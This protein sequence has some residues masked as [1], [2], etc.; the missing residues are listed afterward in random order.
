MAESNS[1]TNEQLEEWLVLR[2]KATPAD[3]HVNHNHDENCTYI[4]GDVT[5]AYDPIATV[6]WGDGNAA[7]HRETANVEFICVSF[8]HFADT[9]RALIEERKRSDKR[10]EAFKGAHVLVGIT[11]DMQR[12]AESLTIKQQGE[13]DRLNLKLW[14]AEGQGKELA[15]ALDLYGDSENWISEILTGLDDNLARPDGSIVA[16]AALA[17]YMA[18]RDESKLRDSR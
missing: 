11:Q 14:R 8:S 10:L 1:P 3:I 2:E 17:R 9:I 12:K 16:S 18:A 6:F 13:I 7:S 5:S 15:K 4:E